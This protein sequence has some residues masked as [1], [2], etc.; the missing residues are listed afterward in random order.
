[1]SQATS[2][3]RCG[4]SRRTGCRL[5]VE[6]DGIGWKGGGLPQGSGLGT[7]IIKAMASNLRSSVVYDPA[8][9]GTRAALEFAV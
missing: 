4:G 9:S 2:A 1:M 7:R 5:V 8:F 3:Y 6:D